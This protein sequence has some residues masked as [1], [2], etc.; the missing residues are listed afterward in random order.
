MK[1]VFTFVLGNALGVASEAAWRARLRRTGGDEHEQIRTMV[2]QA[3]E[4][5]MRFPRL[6][7]HNAA[8]EDDSASPAPDHELEFGLRTILTGLQ[9]ELGTRP[10]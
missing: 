9:A 2:A 3:T 10:S 8:Q 7:A 6:R 4:I 1:T 5:A